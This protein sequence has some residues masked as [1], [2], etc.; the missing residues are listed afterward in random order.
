MAHDEFIGEQPVFEPPQATAEDHAR[1]IG[2][3][4]EEGPGRYVHCRD[5]HETRGC[6]WTIDTTDAEA[7]RRAIEH[8]T[9]TH[10]AEDTP[11]L[12]ERIT[13]R[14]RRRD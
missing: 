11:T 3:G 2:A 7:V 4:I 9:L 12:R 14:V 10:R 1:H 6:N 5:L 13:D 8:V